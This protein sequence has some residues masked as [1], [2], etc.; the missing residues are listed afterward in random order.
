[1]AAG[2]SQPINRKAVAAKI[3][4]WDIEKRRAI[5]DAF[6]AGGA[7]LQCIGILRMRY[8]TGL[9]VTGLRYR[10]TI[11]HPAFSGYPRELGMRVDVRDADASFF[12]TLRKASPEIPFLLVD[13][14]A[15]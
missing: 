10:D 6:T 3:S 11:G 1:M 4:Q 2:M 12:R 5:L 7:F 13:M 9:V 15:A 8:P 14:Q